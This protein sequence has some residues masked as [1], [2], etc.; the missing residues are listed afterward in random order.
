ME[1]VVMDNSGTG[2]RARVGNFR[3]AGKTGTAQN[4]HGE[5]HAVFA[6]FATVDDPRIVVAVVCEES[7]HGGSMAAPVAQK[8]LQQFLTGALPQ[9]VLVDPLSPGDAGEEGEEGD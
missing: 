3:I 7:G 2:G 4:P 6:C 9:D 1:R 5:D 8:V